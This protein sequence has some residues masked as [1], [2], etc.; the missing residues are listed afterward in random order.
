MLLPRYLIKYQFFKILVCK[1]TDI[2]IELLYSIPITRNYMDSLNQLIVSV[3]STK[4]VFY[5]LPTTLYQFLVKESKILLLKYQTHV[6]SIKIMEKYNGHKIF[7]L[8]L[9]KKDFKS[10]HKNKYCYH[11]QIYKNIYTCFILFQINFINSSNI[12][13]F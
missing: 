2:F 12:L 1:N 9:Q 3:H 7:L 5:L 8:M 13:H 4:Y 6:T 11:L 10:K